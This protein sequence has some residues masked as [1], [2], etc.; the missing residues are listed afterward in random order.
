MLKACKKCRREGEKLLIK[1]ERC[2][3]PKCALTKR[4][5]APGDHG[6]GFHGKVSEFGR[7]L[8]EKQ[9]AR[10]IYGIS[11]GQFSKYVGKANTMIGNKS[12]NLMRLLE[13]RIDNVIY[14]LGFAS[15]RSSARQMVSHGLF[16]INGKKVSTASL[17]VKASDVIV[18]KKKEMFKDITLNSSF[19]W[20]EVDTKKLEGSV[21]HLPVR[22]E[23]DTPI[24]E[25]L[26][27]EFYSR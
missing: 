3:S 18:P 11:E 16:N 12:E 9:K 8:R 2:L 1:G 26:I 7:Q 22:D 17:I 21:K 10:R 6:Q 20:L 13:T 27:I 24:N 19:T 5:Y 25:S 4:A 23:I 15:S 14:R